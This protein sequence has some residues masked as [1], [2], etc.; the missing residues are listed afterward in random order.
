MST[1]GKSIT[2]EM[3][4]KAGAL[5]KKEHEL[6]LTLEKQ[7]ADHHLEKRAMRVAF[8]EVEL[9][10]C[11][12]YRSGDEFMEKVASLMVDDLDVVEKALD[13]YHGGT[14]RRAGEL[15]DRQQRSGNALEQWVIHGQET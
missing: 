9:G 5:L 15:E 13:R 10:M 3:V 1:P 4:K 6:R 7:A 11:E 12:P 2:P 8:R 14:A